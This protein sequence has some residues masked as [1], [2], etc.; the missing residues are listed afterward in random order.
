MVPLGADF[1][2]PAVVYARRMVVAHRGE[3]PVAYLP[4]GWVL[5][6]VLCHIAPLDVA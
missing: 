2:D 5:D 3:P 1:V 4:S 6:R